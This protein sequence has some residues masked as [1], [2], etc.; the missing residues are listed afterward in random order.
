MDLFLHFA[1]AGRGKATVAQTGPTCIDANDAKQTPLPSQQTSLHY[2]A[3]WGLHPIV[4]FFIIKHSQYVCSRDSTD[5]ATPLHLASRN[6]HVKAA[7][8]LIGSG[9]DVTALNNDGWTSDC[10]SRRIGDN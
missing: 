4:E 8:K 6:G 9:A 5:N 10:I 2:A 1:D 7:C 3:S